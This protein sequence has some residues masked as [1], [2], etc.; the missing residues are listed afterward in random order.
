MGGSNSSS[1]ATTG[2]SSSSSADAAES[3]SPTAGQLPSPDCNDEPQCTTQPCTATSPCLALTDNTGKTVVDLRMRKLH[4]AT[5]PKLAVAF[6]QQQLVDLGVNLTEACEGG[7]G[8]FSVLLRLDTAAKT[9]TAGGSPPET[10]SAPYCF[11]NTTNNGF[12]VVPVT[13][14]AT[15]ASDGSWQA[16]TFDAP[17]DIPIFAQGERDQLVT[18]PLRNASIQSMQLSTDGN[19][20][21]SYSPVADCKRW[22]PAATLSGYIT[23]E[24][25]DRVPIPQLQ[26]SSLCVLLT[27]QVTANCARDA[28]GKITATGDYCSTTN[29]PATATCADSFWL[30]ATFAASAAPIGDGAGD[31]FCQGASDAAAE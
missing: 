26:D 3:C 20:V 9:L 30:A 23:L 22:T 16:S 15:Q 27:D 19:C 21:G 10:G 17:L 2:G 14:A 24:D 7:D 6:V 25:A 12:N 5:P 18:L 28:S 13:S 8:G 1:T 29:S 31:S 11:V 4:V